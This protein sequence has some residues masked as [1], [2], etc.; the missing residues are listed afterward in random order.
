MNRVMLGRTKSIPAR[1]CLLGFAMTASAW[2]A[3]TTS[4]NQAAGLDDARPDAQSPHTVTASPVF[5]P[6]AG[7]YAAAQ[8]VSIKDATAGA[9]VYFTTNGATPTTASTKYTAPV[10]V[11]VSETLKAI[12]VAPG[13]TQSA[14]ASAKYT[15]ETPTATPTIAPK[16]GIYATAQKVTLADTTAGAAIYYTTNGTAPTSASTKYA[17]AISVSKTETIKAIG[18][19]N[20]HTASGVASAV[21]TIEPKA[22]TPAFSP[23]PG[24]Y[25]SAQSVAVT[26]AT[27]GAAIY[28]TLDGTLPSSSSTH[29]SAPIKIA[30]TTTLK[31]IA[32][33]SGYSSSLVDTGSYVIESRT[34]TPTLLPRP[35]DYS[36]AQTIS[37]SDATS[38]ATIYYTTNGSPPTTASTKYTAPFKISA[39]TPL[40][41]IA[42]SAGHL[43]SVVTGGI[44]TIA[45]AAATPTFAPAPGLYSA[46]VTVTLADK[47]PGATIYYTTNGTPATTAATPYTAPFKI[48]AST[49]V[50]AIADA[51]GYIPSTQ[52]TGN[53][54][55][56]GETVLHSFGG[57]SADG[58]ISEGA[59]IQASDG[60]F[61]GVTTRGGVNSAYPNAGAGTVYKITPAGA[62]TVL[63]A[64]SYGDNGSTDGA[65]PIGVL[66]EGSDRNFYGTTAF[67]G[68]NGYGTVFK[69][70]PSGVETVLHSFTTAVTDGSLPQAGLIDGG[71][72]YFYGT[73]SYGGTYGAGVVFRITPAGQETIVYNFTAG[74]G[75]KVDGAYPVAPLLKGTDGN[76]YGTTA[77]GGASSV[78]TV[79][80]VSPSG[81]ET[82]LHSFAGQPDGSTPGEA[83]IEGLDGNLYGT[84]EFG[85]T[86]NFG[87][88]FRISTGGTEA[89]TYSFSHNVDGSSN[90]QGPNGVLESAKGNFFGT[91][92]AGGK[93]GAGM[94]FEVSPTGVMTVLHSFGAPGSGGTA[95]T[96]G[97]DP[98]AP[99]VLGKDGSLYGTTYTGG[100][101]GYGTVFKVSGVTP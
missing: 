18:I 71:D 50:H 5:S 100:A 95:T 81:S 83:L 8:T 67:G 86:D 37:L 74:A 69:I 38:G 4:A 40:K 6:A 14:V 10:K 97:T 85:G 42:A 22:A 32:V 27:K 59:L 76:F 87:A 7:T 77:E 53:Y 34:A 80:K 23:K 88:I 41:V 57:T 46:A 64:F 60:N 82:V 1:A 44:Y 58:R 89:I 2:A 61:Y 73:A 63:H 99:L 31:A 43:N 45:P 79:F 33:A 101:Y 51:K 78:G 49:V 90:R 65:V 93:Y 75:G 56:G 66:L 39:T 62:L 96:D 13:D 68:V 55:I 84:T 21:F 36:T 20:G 24:S 92:T 12:A 35:G 28:Y 70:T 25:T 16:A 11:S 72:G 94:V 9:D 30:A 98:E 91:T 29:Y 54:V 26:D 19:A 15:I 17:G 52:A 47:T 3:S 48:T